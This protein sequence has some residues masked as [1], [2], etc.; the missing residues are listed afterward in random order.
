MANYNLKCKK[1]SQK[2][3]FIDDSFVHHVSNL[4][5]TFTEPKK[6]TNNPVIRADQPWEK[7]AA[8]VDSGLVLYDEKEKLFKAWYQG[9]AC[10]GPDDNSN[11]C[12][13]TSQDGVVWTKPSLGL[14]D[15]EGSKDNNI[16][17]MAECMMHDA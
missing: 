4:T 5:S 7:D 15:F 14:V 13:A 10:Y 1:L 8:F 6:C 11:M 12:Y 3:L 17:L 2:I 9:G 16:V